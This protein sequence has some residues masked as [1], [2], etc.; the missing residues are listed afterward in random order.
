MKMQQFRTRLR[1]DCICQCSNCECAYGKLD[2]LFLFLC[3]VKL[4]GHRFS[5][6]PS[7]RVS[8]IMAHHHS[9]TNDSV[10]LLNRVSS[11]WALQPAFLLCV[12]LND[13]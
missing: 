3:V 12:H 9:F 13:L 5:V 10:G 7:L 6:K 1:K 4:C 2:L 11:R 8:E